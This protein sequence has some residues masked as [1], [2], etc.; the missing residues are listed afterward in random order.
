MK[1]RL[2]SFKKECQL[3]TIYD[4][5]KMSDDEKNNQERRLFFMSSLTCSIAPEIVP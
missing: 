1:K 5:A 2:K 3:Q 4:L